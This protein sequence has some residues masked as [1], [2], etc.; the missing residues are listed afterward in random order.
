MSSAVIKTEAPR[1]GDLVVGHAVY[2]MLPKLPAVPG[3]IVAVSDSGHSVTV[4]IDRV[5]AVLGGMRRR[6]EFT[7]RA[8]AG[9]YQPKGERTRPGCG[10]ARVRRHT[11]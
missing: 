11:R 10:I 6:W 1:K 8:S 7:W 2:I 5:L 3:R 9:A 4:E